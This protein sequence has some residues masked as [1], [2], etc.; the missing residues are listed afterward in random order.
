MCKCL[1]P[2]CWEVAK[3]NNDVCHVSAQSSWEVAQSSY[4]VCQVKVLWCFVLMWY[5]LFWLLY[6]AKIKNLVRIQNCTRHLFLKFVVF[7]VSPHSELR[8]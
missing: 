7:I 6:N 4:D 5:Y 8:Q 2:S 3:N 1:A